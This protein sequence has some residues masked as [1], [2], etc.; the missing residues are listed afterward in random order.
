MIPLGGQVNPEGAK[1]IMLEDITACLEVI[2]P[3]HRAFCGK[4]RFVRLFIDSKHTYTRLVG[5]F[6]F[7]SESV[8]SI[9][10]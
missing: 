2:F 3:N 8:G 7:L 1:S 9:L 5:F 10:P 6:I 4:P